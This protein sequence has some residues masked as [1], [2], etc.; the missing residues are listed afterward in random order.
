MSYQPYDQATDEAFDRI[1]DPHRHPGGRTM[2][3][4]TDRTPEGRRGQALVLVG[5]ASVVLALCAGAA[6][7]IAAWGLL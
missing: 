4:E 1:T 6:L 5:C 7:I 2:S 3:P